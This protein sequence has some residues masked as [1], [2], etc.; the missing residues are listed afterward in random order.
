[1]QPQFKKKKKK[2]N[3]N[4]NKVIIIWVF[5]ERQLID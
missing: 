3:N 5:W 4:N 2:G 1:M